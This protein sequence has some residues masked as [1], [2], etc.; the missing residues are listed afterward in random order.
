MFTPLN[1]PRLLS[2]QLKG[3]SFTLYSDCPH[4]SCTTLLA[5]CSYPHL[6]LSLQENSSDSKELDQLC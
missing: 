4:W 5:K 2:T 3:T 1:Y 6:R